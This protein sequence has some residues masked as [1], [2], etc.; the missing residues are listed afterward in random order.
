MGETLKTS[1]R[2][3]T[4]LSDADYEVAP[5][6]RDVRGW[7]VVLGDE[8]RIGK[9][10]DLIIEPAAGKVRYLDVDLDR[11]AA[12]IERARHVMVPVG[13]AHLDNAREEVVL[14][15][16]NRAALLNLPDYDGRT[17]TS[18]YDQTFRSHL[19][20]NLK[21]KRVTRSAEELRIGKRMEKKG[22]VRV[23]KHIET[24]HV[25]QTV[26]LTREEVHVERRPVERAVGAAA[27][28]TMMRSSCPSWKKRRWS[29][30]ILS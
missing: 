4:K 19:D 21:S 7:N 12:G 2:S 14:N 5:G 17:H 22:E 30:H 3:L 16:M 18:E 8:E 1:S 13:D 23:S 25:R 27:S 29:R 20:S 26:P 10:D 9:V 15:G 11:K 6:E 28:C 24:E